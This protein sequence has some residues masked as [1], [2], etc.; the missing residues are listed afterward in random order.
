LITA[1]TAVEDSDDDG[2]PDDQD[3]CP[4]TSNTDQADADHDG[5]GDECDE[6]DGVG[7]LRGKKLLVKDQDGAASKRKLVFL[8]KNDAGITTGAAGGWRARRSVV[9]S[10]SW[11]I[12]PRPRT[13]AVSLP[14]E[15]WKGS[16]IPAG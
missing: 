6:E 15:R 8:A 1:V 2:V 7:L 12:P 13:A 4:L 5:V 14:K 3:N 11:P 16:A 9:P 10:S